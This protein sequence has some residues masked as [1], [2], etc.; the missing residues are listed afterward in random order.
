[1]THVL[2]LVVG[3]FQKYGLRTINTIWWKLYIII[4]ECVFINERIRRRDRKRGRA[5]LFKREQRVCDAFWGR[6]RDHT[7]CLLGPHHSLHQSSNKTLQNHIYCLNKDTVMRELPSPPLK[8]YVKHHFT[9]EMVVSKSGYGFRQEPTEGVF[10]RDAGSLLLLVN[11]P[12]V[13]PLRYCG[14][15]KV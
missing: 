7:Y 3:C 13:G 9:G 8:S 10:H 11:F 14:T 6:I 5:V 2:S 1:M 15:I 12:T 4:F